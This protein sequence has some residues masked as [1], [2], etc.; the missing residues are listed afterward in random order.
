MYHIEYP[1][2][3]CSTNT[4]PEAVDV[5]VKRR[6]TVLDVMEQVVDE[7][8]SEYEFSATYFADDRGYNIDSINGVANDA[9]NNCF[10]VLFIQDLDSMGDEERE[11]AD[12]V[13]DICIYGDVAIIWRYIQA[14]EVTVETEPTGAPDSVTTVQEIN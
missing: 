3:A 12:R 6:S 1:D 7:F 8:G 10:W 2:A 14:E 9:T 11:S 13:E 5:E 4:D